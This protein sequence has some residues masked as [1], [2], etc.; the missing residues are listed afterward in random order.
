MPSTMIQPV[1][2]VPPPV[3]SRDAAADA[4]RG[5]SVPVTELL[6]AAARA[7]V[8][9]AATMPLDLVTSIGRSTREGAPYL[10]LRI[11]AVGYAT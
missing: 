7:T 9:I 3:L 8:R 10:S 4:R 5:E 6:Q 11:R 1:R 2:Q